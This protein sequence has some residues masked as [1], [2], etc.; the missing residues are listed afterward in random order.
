MLSRYDSRR[1][2]IIRKFLEPKELNMLITGA[3]A[4]YREVW[5]EP[6]AE[7]TA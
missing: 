6:V 2:Q 3:R 7:H 1:H 4:G 5:L